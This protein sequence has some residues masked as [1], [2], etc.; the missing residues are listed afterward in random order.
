MSSRSLRRTI[1]ALEGT[2]GGVETVDKALRAITELAAIADKIQV[3]E[4][5]G[6]LAQPRHFIGSIKAEG[7]I[8]QDGI[9]E[10]APYITSMALGLATAS[11]SDPY[12]WFFPLPHATAPTFATYTVE[13]T[14]G[15]D[16]IVR[17]TD[18]FAVSLT[19]T[20]EAGQSWSFDASLVGANADYPAALSADIPVSGAVTSIRMA[21][22]RLYLDDTYANVGNTTISGVF[23]NFDWALS[24]LQHQ[25]LFAEGVLYPTGRGHDRY[26]V[27][28]TLTLEAD[29]ATVRSIRDRLLSDAGV[30]ARIEAT[31]GS[32]VAR[33]DGWYMVDSVNT[34]DDR[35]GNNIVEIRLKSE[36]DA[37]DNTG[38]VYYAC[39]LSAL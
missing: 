9:Y 6:T 10:E 13:Y 25:K 24:N 19:I 33:L 15:A 38:L 39:T 4:H 23:I 35:D 27:E 8:K 32:N 28:L 14:D 31:S 30:A 11:G 21:D 17:S 1:V 7:S 37:S 34:L 2:P 20:G 29:N 3:D 26:D 16:Y 18:V 12:N 22:T 36:K 5:V